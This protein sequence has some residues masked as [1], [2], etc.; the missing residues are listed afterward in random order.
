MGT[1]GQ[2]DHTSFSFLGLIDTVEPQ[3]ACSSL[4][5]IH[6]SYCAASWARRPGSTDT[7]VSLLLCVLFQAPHFLTSSSLH[8]SS[9]AAQTY[10]VSCL[11]RWFLDKGS[12]PLPQW[13]DRRNT[14]S[15]SASSAGKFI[16]PYLV[17]ALDKLAKGQKKFPCYYGHVIVQQVIHLGILKI[18]AGLGLLKL[19]LQVALEEQP[20]A[21]TVEEN[22]L[23][24]CH[25]GIGVCS[26]LPL[27]APEP[28]PHDTQAVF[29]SKAVEGL[30]EGR[31]AEGL[32]GDLLLQCLAFLFALHFYAL[33]LV[34]ELL[35]ALPILLHLHA[36]TLQLCLQR[37]QFL[38]QTR[39]GSCRSR[40][41]A[42]NPH[43]QEHQEP[44]QRHAALPT[45]L[46]IPT[47]TGARRCPPC[48]QAGPPHG[49]G[50]ACFS[51]T[52]VLPSMQGQ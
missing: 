7:A 30:L 49:W 11:R 51:L 42:S 28:I 16:D 46:S 3:V 18:N 23:K 1:M 50:S 36:V 17:L 29:T 12:F 14:R 19:Q 47:V 34:F 15:A 2:C 44:A 33:E 48:A 43:A 25:E 40:R 13:E 52:L 20:I 8:S 21:K 4:R 9:L 32:L 37:L 31:R 22:R 45:A 35:D 24:A 26:F 5:T 6:A 10:R 38:A 27:E 41:E 39:L